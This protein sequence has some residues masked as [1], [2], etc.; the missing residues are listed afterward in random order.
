MSLPFKSD[1]L[2]TICDEARALVQRAGDHE[3]N[4]QALVAA[5]ETYVRRAEE[6]LSDALEVT[7]RS[8][9]HLQALLSTQLQRGQDGAE[10]ARQLCADAHE[11]RVAAGLLLTHLDRHLSLERGTEHRFRRN[12]V[13][14]VDDY[15]AIREVVAEVLRNAGFVVRTATNGLEGFLAAYEMRPAVIVM[16]FTM[17]VLDGVEATRFIK[18]TEATRQARVIAYTGNPPLDDVQTLFAAV[19]QKPATPAAILAT[20]QH[21]ASL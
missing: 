16:D 6:A 19:L 14:I 17:P 12:A 13:L 15:E 20:V 21:V 1:H 5:A 10:T 11:Q 3:N 7:H 18:A 9:A 4:L 8:F 2:A